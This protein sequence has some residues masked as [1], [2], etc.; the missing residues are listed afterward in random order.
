MRITTNAIL[1][2]YKSNLGTSLKNL[3]TART[4]VM[5]H[6]KYN[7]TAEDPSSALRAAI[8]ERK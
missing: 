5:T 2:N 8:L 3:D 4:Q 7:S 6:R 1:R